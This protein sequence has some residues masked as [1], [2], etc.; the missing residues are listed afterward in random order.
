MRNVAGIPQT[1]AQKSSDLYAKCRYMDE[2]TG[3]RGVIFATGTPVSNSMTEMFTMMRYLQNDTLKHLGLSQFDAWA[4]TFGETV[5]AIELAPTGTGYRAK[6][7]FAKFYNL[8]ELMTTFKEVADVKTADELN[9]PRP[10]ANFHVIAVQPTDEQTELMK[11]LSDRAAAIHDKEVEPTEDNM[12]KVTSDGRKIGL[13]QR[14][15]DPMLPDDPGSKVN[16]CME[17]VYRIWDE[18]K[19]DRLTQVVFCDFSTPSKDK[20]NVYDDIKSKLIQKGIPEK[21]IAYI[22]D[23]DSE[24]KK[25]ELFARVRKGQVRILMGSTAK[26]GSGTNVQDKLI[27]LHDLDCPWRPA[28]LEQRSGRIIRQGNKNP[29]VDIFRYVTRSTFDSYLFQT[30]ENKQKFISQIM[31]SKNP[32]RTCDDVDESVL[33]YAEV[34]AL[35]IGNPLIKE[36]M[37]L[38]IQVARLRVLEG[39]HTSQQYQLQDKVLKHYP[40]K[41]KASKERI[42]GLEKDLET[43]S[44]HAD[45]KFS[46]TVSGRTFGKDEKGEAGKA[47]LETCRGARGI[48]TTAAIGEYKG[49][50][51]GVSYSYIRETFELNLRADGVTHQV[52]LG[53]SAAGN[54]TRIDNT[55]EKIPEQ[56]KFTKEYL[57]DLEKQL[58]N[59][60]EELGRPFPQAQE[61]KEKSARLAELDILLSMDSSG[62]AEQENQN[63]DTA[64]QKQEEEEGPGNEPREEAEENIPSPVTQVPKLEPAVPESV[65]GGGGGVVTFNIDRLRGGWAEA[66]SA[67][68]EKLGE[69][70]TIAKAA[71]DENYYG[72]ILA[73]SETYAVQQTAQD[74]VVLHNLFDIPKLPEIL[75]RDG[76]NNTDKIA[77]ICDKNGN[78]QV[79]PFPKSRSDAR[80]FARQRSGDSVDPAIVISAQPGESYEGHI[81]KIYDDCI[82]QEGQGNLYFLHP[83]RPFEEN[84]SRIESGVMITLSRSQEGKGSIIMPA[85]TEIANSVPEDFQR[86]QEKQDKNEN[87]L[88]YSSSGEDRSLIFIPQI[89]QRV[90]FHPNGSTVKLTGLVTSIEE[91]TITVQAGTKSI[92]IYKDKGRFVPE[93]NRSLAVTDLPVRESSGLGF[94]R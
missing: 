27:A 59:A 30:V 82:L 21:E 9:L 63:E 3:N 61:L 79:D 45:E 8:P 14:L 32:A 22:H 25:K 66:A 41:I 78:Q 60:K 74:A 83:R 29:E 71:P 88:N 10:K 13:D 24:E 15:I 34:K 49:F 43:C 18:T 81:V 93:E 73:I 42:A 33:S 37:D 44:L 7:R 31:T 77:I 90:V 54:L 50:T 11:T 69:N 36:K 35:C 39:S 4:A 89:G 72:P 65:T 38:D 1:E 48:T 94:E 85:V 53:Q 46:M 47:I 86:E 75:K 16:A 6:T 91:E 84:L 40:K 51:M 80:L 12:L 64:I 62:R 68:Q 87:L 55:L 26:M 17:N 92:P 5:T 70:V 58:E 23:A 52:E 19:N 56:L 76:L 67:A 57:S 20:F 2:S 28:D